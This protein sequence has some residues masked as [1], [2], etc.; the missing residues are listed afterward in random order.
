MGS[1]KP[2]YVQ[3]EDSL[4]DQIEAG[5]INGGEHLPSA[6]SLAA[7]LG[8][9]LHTVLKAYAGLEQAG[10]VE[11]RRGRGG[12]VVL[13]RPKLT[14]HLRAAIEA[15]RKKGTGINEVIEQIKEMWK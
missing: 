7:S 11:M 5:S 9:N 15:A 10:L 13:D 14:A 2:I 1:N 6:R 4:R 12:V 3:I 8:I